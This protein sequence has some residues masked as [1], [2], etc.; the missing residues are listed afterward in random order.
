MQEYKFVSDKEFKELAKDPETVQSSNIGI[1]KGMP[2]EVRIVD[3]EKRL[4]D[5]IISTESVDRMFDTI[6]VKGWQLDNFKN[7]PVVLFGHD[8]NSPPIAKAIS[9]TKRPKLKKLESRAEFMEKE[10]SP[11]SDMIFQM[12]VNGFMKA[13]SVGFIPLEWQLSEDEERKAHYGIDFEKQEL[14]EY[15]VVSV[16]ANPE[17]IM[18][19]RSKGIDTNP[20]YEWSGKTLDEFDTHKKSGLI[21][22][23]KTLE[24]LYKH[25]DPKGRVVQASIKERA[26]ELAKENVEKIKKELRGSEMITLLNY[27]KDFGI[28]LP[29]PISAFEGEAPTLEE[30]F[31]FAED[32]WQDKN[33]SVIH[34][35]LLGLEIEDDKIEDILKQA[36]KEDENWQTEVEKL[37]ELNKKIEDNDLELENDDK[38]LDQVA[39][40]DLEIDDSIFTDSDISTVDKEL[41]KVTDIEID[42]EALSNE[43]KLENIILYVENIFDNIEQDSAIN[44]LDKIKKTRRGK[45]LLK[46]LKDLCE[47]FIKLIKENSEIDDKSLDKNIET[48]DTYG[49]NLEITL[50]DDEDLEIDEDLLVKVINEVLPEIIKE[51]CKYAISSLTGKID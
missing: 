35:I 30:E 42:L 11:F 33:V 37:L 4:I 8:H 45:R 39:D 38:K 9:I 47:D 14:L 20:L 23:R 7:N 6:S 5:F 43:D 28:E 48:L 44:V 31:K 22:P 26:K 24:Q 40:D 36:W 50:S 25:S 1:H 32:A 17:A 49:D 18:G 51:E 29:N 41:D 13:T 3:R 16:P 21:I 19:M 12:Y 46:D 34:D 15:S 27:L 10:L 2:C